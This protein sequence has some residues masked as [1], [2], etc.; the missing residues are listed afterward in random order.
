MTLKEWFASQPRGTQTELA[1]KLGV[2]KTWMTLVTNGHQAPGPELAVMI[3]QLTG[4]AVT[5]EELR[6]D[7]F[8]EIK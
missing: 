4:G 1:K 7:L 3:H 6:P 2:S 5:R 8:G